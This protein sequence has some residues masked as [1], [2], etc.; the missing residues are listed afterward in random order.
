MSEEER[1]KRTAK[2]KQCGIR[3]EAS[4]TRDILFDWR[5]CPY[6]CENDYEHYLAEEE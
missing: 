5:D 1:Q 4:K 2:C 3:Q 6:N